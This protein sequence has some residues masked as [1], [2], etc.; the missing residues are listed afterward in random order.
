MFSF[1]AILVVKIFVFAFRNK[2][3]NLIRTFF[4]YV[5]FVEM[6]MRTIRFKKNLMCGLIDSV[7]VCN[8]VVKRRTGCGVWIES[9][10]C[11]E[12]GM[13]D[14]LKIHQNTVTCYVYCATIDYSTISGEIIGVC[15]Q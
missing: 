10:K 1:L 12:F 4:F 2:V 11:G 9:V 3:F 13:V 7:C 6:K 8:Y 15:L 5:R 14:I